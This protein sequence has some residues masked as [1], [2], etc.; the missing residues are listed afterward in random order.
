LKPE[1]N[2]SVEATRAR[3]EAVS[4]IARLRAVDAN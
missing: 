3:V 4:D 1:L 2:A